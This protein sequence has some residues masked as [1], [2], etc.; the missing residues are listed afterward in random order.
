MVNIGRVVDFIAESHLF[1]SC[2]VVLHVARLI[3]RWA[4]GVKTPVRVAPAL[5]SVLAPGGDARR[6]VA[7][8]ARGQGEASEWGAPCLPVVGERKT[9][10]Q[11][12]PDGNCAI[13]R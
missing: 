11:V 8:A 5:D 4:P 9:L 2:Q 12:L 7:G 10:G 1:H 3:A 6:S 13:G